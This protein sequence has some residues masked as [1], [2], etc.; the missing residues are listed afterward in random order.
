MRGL[1]AAGQAAVDEKMI[2]ADGTPNKG[3]LG[4][5]ALLGVSMAVDGA[6]FRYF[7]MVFTG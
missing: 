5:N 3:K 2:E 7:A 1:D 6:G 4:A